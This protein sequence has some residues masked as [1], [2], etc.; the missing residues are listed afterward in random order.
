MSTA[1]AMIV[2]PDLD[3]TTDQK[4]LECNSTRSAYEYG[5]RRWNPLV[6][7]WAVWVGLVWLVLR[8]TSILVPVV[9]VALVPCMLAY[10]IFGEIGFLLAMSFMSFV[11]LPFWII[12]AFVFAFPAYFDI[13]RMSGLFLQRI[14]HLRPGETIG[15]VNRRW[16]DLHA[17]G[18]RLWRCW[19]ARP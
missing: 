3:L 14:G 11:A 5:L 13:L 19:L 15:T 17:D 6:G 10:A 8:M 7:V 12:P 18:R 9:L 2:M 16:D 4:A 1:K